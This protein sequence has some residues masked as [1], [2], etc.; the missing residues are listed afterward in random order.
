MPQ[1]KAAYHYFIEGF[2]FLNKNIEIYL[3]LIVISLA[4]TLLSIHSR[5]I[6]GLIFLFIGLFL[7]AFHWGYLTSVPVFFVQKKNGK[8]L[9]YKYILD[10][11]LQVTKRLIVPILILGL[12]FFLFIIGFLIV[13]QTVTNGN[14]EKMKAI[15]QQLQNMIRQPNYFVIFLSS[16]IFSFFSFFSIFFSL[17]KYSFINSIKKS[18][19]F[20]F[21]NLQFII[22]AFLITIV[23]GYV[24][25]AVIPASLIGTT[26]GI[27]WFGFFYQG[28]MLYPSLVVT[29]SALLYYQDYQ[30][31]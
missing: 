10:V 19:T 21:K 5:S 4:S 24:I 13:E 8:K 16:L 11:S 29:A 14:V 6:F 7:T 1:R 20:S 12:L 26:V 27:T 25:R 2:S 23:S 22:L 30:K 3:L 15:N 17:E 28:L 31:A 18:V 9:S